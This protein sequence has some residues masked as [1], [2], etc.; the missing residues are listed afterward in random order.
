MVW[1]NSNYDTIDKICDYVSNINEDVV[2]DIRNE[3]HMFWFA[4]FFENEIPVG[5]YRLNNILDS[6]NIKF[7]LLIGCEDN[8]WFDYFKANISKNFIIE[9]HP[10]SIINFTMESFRIGNVDIINNSI[11]KNFTHLYINYNNKVRSHRCVM[12]DELYKN[13]LFSYGKNSY[14]II[15]HNQVSYKFKHWKEEILKIDDYKTN[16]DKI[17]TPTIFDMNCLIN[18]ATETSTG[19]LVV[20]IGRAHV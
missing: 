16:T 12:L 19:V 17:I 5:F 3:F 15:N 9:F 20:K 11:T 1:I 13:D 6:K 8:E 14:N 4:P 2:F 18:L 10:L 7:Y